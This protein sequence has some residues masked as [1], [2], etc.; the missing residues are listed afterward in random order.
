[1]KIT[2]LFREPGRT[3]VEVE[4]SKK[5][6]FGIGSIDV[7]LCAL[8]VP[9]VVKIPDG[10]GS[11][12]RMRR[13]DGLRSGDSLFRFS[14]TE[15]TEFTEGKSCSCWIWFAKGQHGGVYDS[16]DLPAPV[17][18]STALSVSSVVSSFG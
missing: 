2:P 7:P 1:V 16:L 10:K 9:C 12:F 4:I 13:L 14:T 18:A 8:C 6:W 3:G 5:G 17:G 15:S 11:N